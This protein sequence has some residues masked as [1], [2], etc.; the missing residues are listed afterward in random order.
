MTMA[1][2]GAFKQKVADVRAVNDID[3]L[4]NGNIVNVRSF[5]VTPAQ[6][7]ANLIGRY[8]SECVVNRGDVHSD[9]YQWLPAQ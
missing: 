9:C 4:G 5:A 3:N 2:I 7:Q 6:V 8:T 1:G